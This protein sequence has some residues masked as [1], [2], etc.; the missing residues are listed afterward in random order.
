MTVFKLFNHDI[1]LQPDGEPAITPQEAPKKGYRHD[2]GTSQSVTEGKGSVNGF[3]TDK[4]CHS[5]ADNIVL[6]LNRAETAAG[7]L[8]GHIQ[9]QPEGLQ[10]C[11]AAQR[12]PDS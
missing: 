8:S 2:Y 10:Q 11:I 3:Q 4:L 6:P 5:E 12:A 1:C 7:S 9:S